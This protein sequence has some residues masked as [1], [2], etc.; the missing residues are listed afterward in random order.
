[1]PRSRALGVTAAEGAAG[2]T[3]CAPGGS[4][5]ASAASAR[6]P[7]SAVAAAISVTAGASASA[8]HSTASASHRAHSGGTTRGATSKARRDAG[9][10]SS[11]AA[12]TATLPTA[13]YKAGWL[14]R[15]RTRRSRVARVM[16]TA[17]TIRKPIA[18]IGRLPARWMA[19]LP[20]AT[21]LAPAAM[22]EAHS[23]CS[24]LLV[25]AEPHARAAQRCASVLAWIVAAAAVVR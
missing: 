23:T 11:G 21:V 2:P 1:M 15:R 16:Y 14:A 9:T 7:Q 17:G 13:S 5:L 20:N 22:P 24:S 6:Q 25:E 18:R 4:A 19:R 12:P 8:R 10:K 3:S